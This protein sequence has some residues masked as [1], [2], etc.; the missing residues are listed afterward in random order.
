MCHP[1]RVRPSVPP[2]QHPQR[3]E[4]VPTA[5]RTEA[6]QF[7]VRLALPAV[8]QRPAAVGAL[9]ATDDVDRFAEAPV[10]RRVDGLEIIESAE[11]VVVPARREREAKEDGLDD[12]P[13]RSERKS[14]CTKRNSWPR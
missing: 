7:E 2:L 6:F 11:D 1:F 4:C 5:R 8:L 3:A 13:V 14:R 9:G 10:P 12:V